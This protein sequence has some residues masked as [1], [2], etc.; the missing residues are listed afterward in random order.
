MTCRGPGLLNEPSL[1]SFL[2][3]SADTGRAQ[4][5]QPRAARDS[6]P[7]MRLASRLL[8]MGELVSGHRWRC[9]GLAFG[10][11]PEEGRDNRRRFGDDCQHVH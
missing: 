7:S 10:Q 1:D 5:R 8:G 6:C 3:T 9:A 2:T 4:P 11:V